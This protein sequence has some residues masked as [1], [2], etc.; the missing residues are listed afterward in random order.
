MSPGWCWKYPNLYQSHQNGP[1]STG[2]RCSSG[3]LLGMM[4]AGIDAPTRWETSTAAM[5]LICTSKVKCW[6][7]TKVRS[8]Y[9]KAQRITKHN[10]TMIVHQIQSSPQ[11]LWGNPG[12]RRWWRRCSWASSLWLPLWLPSSSPWLLQWL[13]QWLGFSCTADATVTQWHRKLRAAKQVWRLHSRS[14]AANSSITVHSLPTGENTSAYDEYENTG[15]QSVAA[16]SAANVLL[17]YYFH[18]C[19]I[20][21]RQTMQSTNT[22]AYIKRLLNSQVSLLKYC[23]NSTFGFMSEEV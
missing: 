5:T 22:A 9:F 8:F 17:F 6:A 20:L 1:K 21:I 16:H 18:N 7:I 19:I 23:K 11:H 12:R 3:L 15:E 14:R 4:Q 2:R 10:I 13:L